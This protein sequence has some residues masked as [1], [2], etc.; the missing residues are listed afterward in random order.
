MERWSN[1]FP[2]E[3]EVNRYLRISTVKGFSLYLQLIGFNSYV[4]KLPKL[5]SIYTPY[6]FTEDEMVRIFKE[7]DRLR[8]SKN[9]P[10]SVKNMIPTLIRVLYGTGIRISEAMNLTHA[11]VNLEEGY[12]HITECKNNQDRIV[13]L[14]IS[15]RDVCKEYCLYKHRIGLSAEPHTPFFTSDKGEK[16]SSRSIYR[17][18][19]MILYRAGIPHGGRG[20]GP[21]LHDLRH[22]FCV[23]S[24]IKLS[25]EGLDLYYSLPILMTYVGHSS[26]NATNRYVRMTKELYPKILSRIDATYQSIFPNLP[27]NIED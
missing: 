26:I 2:L 14:S 12:M 3:T 21:R 23:N 18:F 15:V 8:V 25:E 10:R 16:G 1:H 27:P 17:I 6:I 20:K 5:R 11:N 7:C 4:P 19:R 22:T 13:P 24:L 9:F